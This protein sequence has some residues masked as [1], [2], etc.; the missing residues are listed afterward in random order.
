MAKTPADAASPADRPFVIARVF[1]APRELVWRVWTEREHLMR[2]WGPKGVTIASCSNDLRP[3]GVFHYCM[4]MP[5][6]KEMWGKWVYREIVRPERLVAVTSFSDKDGGLTRHPLAPDWP[7]EM[8]S[9]MSFA[10]QD[11]R[12]KVTIEWSPLSPTAAERKTF[13]EG[14]GSMQQ[15]WTGTLDQLAEY[16]ARARPRCPP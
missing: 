15:G 11:G 2:W 8:L 12:T 9:A 14:R 10:E 6:G 7:R 16:L 5:D 4:H 13:E 3:G 1:D